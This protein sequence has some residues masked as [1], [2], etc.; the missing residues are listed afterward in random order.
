MPFSKNL[1]TYADV[2]AI[3]QACRKSGAP[4]CNYELETRGLAVN[5]RARAYYY[6]TLL[7]NLAKQRLSIPGFKTSRSDSS[8]LR[9]SARSHAKARSMLLCSIPELNHS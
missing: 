9:A 8:S 2:E 6:R 7:R 1:H 3:L 4:K 5:W